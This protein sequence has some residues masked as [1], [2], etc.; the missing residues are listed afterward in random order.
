[1]P[2]LAL[3]LSTD[4][5]ASQACPLLPP[6]PRPELGTA[7]MAVSTTIPRY[8][9]MR[10]WSRAR[11]IF[12]RHVEP[13]R[14]TSNHTRN[15][16]H[17][18]RCSCAISLRTRCTIH[19]TGISYIKRPFL[20]LRGFP[21]D[22]RAM[23][24]SVELQNEVARRQSAYGTDE[25]GPGR[26]IW[27]TPTELFKV[28]VK[29]D[30]SPIHNINYEIGVGNRPLAIDIPGRIGS[31]YPEVCERTH[32]NIVEIN[33]RL[34][35]LREELL[36]PRRPCVSIS[37]KSIFHWDR[38][39][40]AQSRAQFFFPAM[41]VMVMVRHPFS[42]RS[43]DSRRTSLRSTYSATTIA[44]WTQAWN[45]TRASS[46]STPT[47]TTAYTTRASPTRLSP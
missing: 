20:C 31:A 39:E 21:I 8:S 40:P 7:R 10:R 46:P 1:M 33:G 6:S 22:F 19:T 3:P 11:A 35:K 25:E 9:S 29:S 37:D 13:T 18:S 45:L 2:L 27:H 44:A 26:Q 34:A 47:A 17:A 36:V 14:T 38:R 23:R 16:Q 12:A 5:H 30:K 15:H 41:E 43:F 32:Y 4:S 42:S 28:C 24:D